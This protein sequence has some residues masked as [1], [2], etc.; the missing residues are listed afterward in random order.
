VCTSL[1]LFICIW[2]SDRWRVVVVLGGL[3]GC[4]QWRGPPLLKNPHT[5]PYH[6]NKSIGCEHLVL[7]A[8]LSRI[9]EQIQAISFARWNP[10]LSEEVCPVMSLNTLIQCYKACDTIEIIATSYI[11]FPCFVKCIPY[12]TMHRY[13]LWSL[14]LTLTWFTLV[15]G[16]PVLCNQ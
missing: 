6:L 2:L 12:G 13:W 3:G 8:V 10:R 4:W 5:T 16:D 11:A 9:S 14:Q 15:K 1:Q 7:S